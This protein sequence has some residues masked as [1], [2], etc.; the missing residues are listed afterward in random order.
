[1]LAVPLLAVKAGEP[2]SLY[3]AHNAL[4]V[5]LTPDDARGSRGA[6]VRDLSDPSLAPAMVKQ[7][8]HASH[9]GNVRQADE[10]PRL[11]Q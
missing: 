7:F 11:L 5:A 8:V 9:R 3:L 10:K 1:M 2:F 4:H 6:S